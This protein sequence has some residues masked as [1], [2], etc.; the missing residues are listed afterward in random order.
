[1]GRVALGFNVL[2]AACSVPVYGKDTPTWLDW[3]SW[4]V[5]LT[6]GLLNVLSSVSFSAGSTGSAVS[7]LS[8]ELLF[9]LSAVQM[10]VLGLMFDPSWNE[11][12]PAT[13]VSDAVLGI[14]LATQLAGVINPAKLF[15]E[16]GAIVV[17]AVDVIMGIAAMVA[18]FLSVAALGSAP[19]AQAVARAT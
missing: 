5:S 17:A 18:G 19:P 14:N 6:A 7:Q 4:G 8:P 15:S 13:P 16:I 11:P 12:P 2:A 1:V 10:L 9:G 3:T